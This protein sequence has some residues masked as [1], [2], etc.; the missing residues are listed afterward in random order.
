L[1]IAVAAALPPTLALAARGESTVVAADEDELLTTSG[2]GSE[3][4]SDDA[5][6][7]ARKAD[8]NGKRRS[9]R[10]RKEVG[11]VLGRLAA[12]DGRVS[13]AEGVAERAQKGYE[14][15]SRRT[16][17]IERGGAPRREG[18]VSS[19]AST[20]SFTARAAAT[21]FVEERETLALVF[22]AFPRNT[23][24][25]DGAVLEPT[26]SPDARGDVKALG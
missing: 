5:P 17:A 13:R 7:W 19:A 25:G 4:L 2:G 6:S 21:S 11:Q 22:G 14:D 8:R 15:L 10:L 16:R 26:H 24:R 23:G 3:S 18:N 12:L 1:A 9:R 20:S